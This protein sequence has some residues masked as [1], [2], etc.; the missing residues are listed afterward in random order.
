VC[1]AVYVGVG[2]VCVCVCVCVVRSKQT[3]HQTHKT[4]YMDIW[5]SATRFGFKI[6]PSSG[7]VQTLKT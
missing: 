4:T 3:T 5:R 7:C 6:K 2:C 1:V